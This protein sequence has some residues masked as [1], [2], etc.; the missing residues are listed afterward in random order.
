MISPVQL[1]GKGSFRRGSAAIVS[2]EA[3]MNNPN[4]PT[5]QNRR[6]VRR[7]ERSTPSLPRVVFVNSPLL[8]LVES[9]P[10]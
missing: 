2:G 7:I 3:A 4:N 9:R 5:A 8:S 10:N 6:F 1:G